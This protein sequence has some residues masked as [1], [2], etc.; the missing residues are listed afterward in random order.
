MYT[1]N[2]DESCNFFLVW[3]FPIIALGMI[4]EKYHRT[5]DSK[6]VVFECAICH[7]TE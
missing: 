4:F 3:Y 1:E 5:I 7:T 2:N 6:N